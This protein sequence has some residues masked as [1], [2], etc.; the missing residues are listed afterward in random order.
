MLVRKQ[1]L[2]LLLLYYLGFSG[3][4]NALFRF[5]SKPIARFVTFHDI[6]N[7]ADANFRATLRFLKQNTNVISLDEFFAGK[8][9]CKMINTVITFDDGY[10]SWVSNALPALKQFGLPSTFFVSSGF[11]GL[12]GDD[13]AKFIRSKLK[14]SRKTSGGLSE[15][16]V[17]VIA[18][19]NFTIGGHT[20]NHLNL[21]EIRDM[22]ELKRE[23]FAD[24]QRLESII[25][26]EIQYFAYPFGAHCNPN[27]DVVELLKEAGYKGA[28]TTVSGFNTVGS[29]RYLLCRE[30]TGVPMPLC[31]FK[32]RVQGS[33]DG[34]TFL[35]NQG[36]NLLGRWNSRRF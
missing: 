25:R 7:E 15:T 13:E 17:R 22:A 33:Y 23:I 34:I 29:N 1:D 21:A 32:A 4:R 6:P 16:D 12:S 31:V 24:K 3:M 35:R 19:E 14:T 27:N 36:T 28:L 8:L 26:K 9:S 18:D 2:C 20:C 30:L 10:K 11:L 5:Q